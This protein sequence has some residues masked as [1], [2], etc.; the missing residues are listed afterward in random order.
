M[1]WTGPK[2]NSSGLFIA[3]EKHWFQ[4][5]AVDSPE[6][7]KAPWYDKRQFQMVEWAIGFITMITSLHCRQELGDEI[8]HFNQAYLRHE[9]SPQA[10]SIR[11]R[12]SY[13][14]RSIVARIKQRVRV[15]VE[16]EYFPLRSSIWNGSFCGPPLELYGLVFE[17]FRSFMMFN[18]N[19]C[20][21]IHT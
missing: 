15:K 11:V 4:I 6:T 9:H 1:E 7:T 19:M 21:F 14:H 17:C 12:I 16:R 3:V 8:A 13:F 18:Y 10:P 2:G 20:T 5:P